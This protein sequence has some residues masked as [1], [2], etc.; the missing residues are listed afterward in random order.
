MEMDLCACEYVCVCVVNDTP[1]QQMKKKR[2]THTVYIN[3]KVV[4]KLYVAQSTQEKRKERGA[5]K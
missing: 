1:K 4:N 3:I 2:T 5:Q